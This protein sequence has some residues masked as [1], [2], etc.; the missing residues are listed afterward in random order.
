MPLGRQRF[1]DGVLGF[2]M[3]SGDFIAPDI[4]DAFPRALVLDDIERMTHGLNEH[5]F[6]IAAKIAAIRAAR[7]QAAP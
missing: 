1:P 4:V 3:A 7:L 2:E 5:T 6:L